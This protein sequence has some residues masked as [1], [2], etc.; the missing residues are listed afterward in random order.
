MAKTKGKTG[1]VKGAHPRA[2][3]AVQVR[4]CRQQTGLTQIDFARKVGVSHITVS[5]WENGW[6]AP[7]RLALQRIEKLARNKR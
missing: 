6:F 2:K 4:R 1:E 3:S 5:R 7:S